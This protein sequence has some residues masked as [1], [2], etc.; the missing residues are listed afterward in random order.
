MKF[1]IHPTKKMKNKLKIMR[2]C[3]YRF[4]CSTR[5]L[6]TYTYIKEILNYIAKKSSRNR[7]KLSINFN[8]IFSHLSF[9]SEFPCGNSPNAQ[10]CSLFYSSRLKRKKQ[11]VSKIYILLYIH[12]ATKNGKSK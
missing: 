2:K 10:K 8:A 4:R 12:I 3:R 11:N 7:S 5:E 6:Y 9:S 1:S